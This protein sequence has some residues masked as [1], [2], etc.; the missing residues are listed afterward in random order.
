MRG[1]GNATEYYK[2]FA[3]SV[4]SA[5]KN[6]ELI[7]KIE[8]D[9]KAKVK[10]KFLTDVNSETINSYGLRDERYAG[11][12]GDGIPRPT[13]VIIDKNRKI[14]MIRIEDDYRKRPKIED[15]ELSI[16]RLLMDTK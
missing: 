15:I 3:I 13:I 2:M 5:D 12:E 6:K 10:Y 1:I 4:D 14:Y 8:A 7:K 11:K 9:G 16:I